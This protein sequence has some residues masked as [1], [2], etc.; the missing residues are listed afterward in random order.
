MDG[1][2]SAATEASEASITLTYAVKP[3]IPASALSL[4]NR[5]VRSPVAVYQFAIESYVYPP[6]RANCE[7]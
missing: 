6:P 5:P 7:E 1:L 2:A 3:A 4:N